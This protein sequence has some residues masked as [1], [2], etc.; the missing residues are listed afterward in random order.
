MWTIESNNVA[1]LVHEEFGEVPWNVGSSEIRVLSEILPDSVCVISVDIGF[2]HN[3]ESNTVLFLEFLYLLVGA[4]FLAAKLI[5]G[6]GNNFETLLFVL[7]LQLN[8]SGV[9]R[10]GQTSLGSDVGN[11]GN[12]LASKLLHGFDFLA[13][14][15]NSRLIEEVLTSESVF[16]TSVFRICARWISQ[17]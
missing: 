7:L 8:E 11:K 12:I 9:V 6:I 13:I 14:D 2:V 10:I 15:G 5:A 3:G 4:R 1:V 16:V 17:V